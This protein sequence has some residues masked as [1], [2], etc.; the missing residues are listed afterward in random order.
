MGA[1]G[2]TQSASGTEHRILV[3]DDEPSI[4]DAVATALRYEG[5]EV[6]E[7]TSGREALAAVARTAAR[8]ALARVLQQLCGTV[9]LDGHLIGVGAG[10]GT[11][12]IGQGAR[13]IGNRSRPR[14]YTRVLEDSLARYRFRP[15][16]SV[17]RPGPYTTSMTAAG[18]NL[19][20]SGLRER[21]GLSAHDRHGN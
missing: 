6:D 5:Y 1:N 2:T 18:Q 16:G 21:L 7:A 14:R 9:E 3:V 12:G 15:A 17:F 8:P 13:R 19:R 4:V 11:P 10:G 20:S